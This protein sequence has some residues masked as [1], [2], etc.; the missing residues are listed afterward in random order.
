MFTGLLKSRRGS[1]L[2][3]AAISLTAMLIFTSFAVDVSCILTARNQLQTSVDA[4]ALAGASGLLESYSEAE[5]RAVT[6]A[7]LNRVMDQ[8]VQLSS[9]NDDGGGDITF[10]QSNQV[11][12]QAG[13]DV[14]LYFAPLM[15]LQSVHITAEATAEINRIV[16]TSGMRPWG[17]PD[18]GWTV[19][20]PVVI[21]AGKTGAPATNPSF[22]YPIDFPPMNRG[23]P[24]RGASAYEDNIMYGTR[25]T[26][27]IGDQIQVEPGNMTGP[28]KK[29]V[30]YLIDLDPN[31]YWN[32]H[33]VVGSNYPGFSSPRII[34]IPLYDPDNPP[35]SG[36]KFIDC[37][38]L[39]AFFVQAMTGKDVV[40]IFLRTITDGQTGNGYSYLRG[41]KLIN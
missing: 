14:N 16:A 35:D 29:G 24:V 12:V 19:G 37:I 28:T 9:S 18:F 39:G 8:P 31:A 20:T 6:F 26:V 2:V 22:F 34:K 32:G 7:S 17:V 36:R 41:V 11:R 13:H 23:K 30:D 3:F 25:F 4:A 40:G 38:G 33:E 27:K 10:P 15:G 1:M 5:R 21:K